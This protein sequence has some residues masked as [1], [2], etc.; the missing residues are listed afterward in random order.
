MDLYRLLGLNRAASADEIERAYRRLARRYHPG[1]NPGDRVAEEMYRQIQHA[2]A[3]LAD[4]ERRREYD[5]GATRAQVP[6]ETAVSFEGFDFSA[7]AEGPLAA[8]FA[9]LF[10]G[11]FHQARSRGHDA[12]ARRRPRGD[13]RPVVHRG[14]E[15]GA[16]SAERASSG[17]M[18]GVRRRRPRAAC[19]LSRV[20]PA[21]GKGPGV[22]RAGTWCSRRRVRGAPA[23]VG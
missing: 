20:R 13:P 21:G 15:W 11:V 5:R 8:T 18:P 6:V 14:G 19:R 2:Y 16:V 22:L 1:V 3:V 12:V 23:A 9:E 17:T 7:P 10:A 4:L